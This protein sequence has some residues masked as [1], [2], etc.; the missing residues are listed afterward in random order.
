MR[1]ARTLR[2]C[3]A[4]LLVVAGLVLIS[5]C[6]GL[7]I[8][9]AWRDRDVVIDGVPSEWQGPSAWVENPNVAISAMND[10]DYLY[11]CFSTPVHGIA[12]E[13]VQ[14][15]MT[16]WFDPQGKANKVFGIHCPVGFSGAPGDSGR[17]REMRAAG[18][19]PG[20]EMRHHSRGGLAPDSSAFREMGGDWL[21]SAASTLQ[22]LRP[23]AGDTLNLSASEADGVQVMLGHDSG[24][25]VYELRVPLRSE[26]GRTCGVGYKGGG[27][28]S[29]GF[30]T[31]EANREM[32]GREW[33]RQRSPMGGEGGV[34]GEG[35][36]GEP[37][38]GGG[39]EGGPEGGLGGR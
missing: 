16:V 20:G 10:D 13:I 2:T 22:V 18:G 34:G 8:T 3:R 35:W 38:G 15:G 12:A 14:Q 9:S 29:I 36:G 37:G 23:D 33:D 30:E 11:L 32:S 7:Q 5:G 19:G 27:K 26:A 28:V 39:R 21:R 6:G 31:P 1:H 4:A 17:G 25:F 24:R